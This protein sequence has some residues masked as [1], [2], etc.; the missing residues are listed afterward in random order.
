MGLALVG[1]LAWFFLVKRK[2]NNPPSAQQAAPFPNPNN[3]LSSPLP[4]TSPQPPQYYPPPM[5][6][7]PTQP[8]PLPGMVPYGVA[9]Q[10]G[11]AS[12]PQPSASSPLAPGQQWPQQGGSTMAGQPMYDPSPSTS[13]PPQFVQ[14]AQY[15]EH[16]GV[17]KGPHTYTHEAGT[18]SNELEGNNMQHR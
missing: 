1:F 4:P 18:F 13:P 16:G 6:Q 10:D 8:G 17:Y 14:P 7:N 15:A 5:Q 9:K 11:W 12:S 2:K 3:D